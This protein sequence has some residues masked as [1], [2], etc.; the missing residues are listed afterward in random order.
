MEDSKIIE[1]LIAFASSIVLTLAGPLVSRYLQ[2]KTEKL[3]KKDAARFNAYM[4]L[5]ETNSTYFWVV[6]VELHKEEVPA[7]IK[8]RLREVT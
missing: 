2:V 6:T 4:N 5:R 8:R 3:K 7:D 1:R